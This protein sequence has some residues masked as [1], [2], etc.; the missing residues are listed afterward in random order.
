MKALGK[1]FIP[2]LVI[3]AVCAACLVQAE[4]EELNAFQLHEKKAHADKHQ[5]EEKYKFKGYSSYR[6]AFAQI[7]T[8]IEQDG[9]LNWMTSKAQQY[10]YLDSDCVPCRTLY[11]SLNSTCKPRKPSPVKLKK[12]DK[13][14][15][16]TKVADSKKEGAEGEE[17]KKPVEVEVKKVEKK[18]IKLDPSTE[19]LDLISN[20]FR[21]MA[22]KEPPEEAFGYF[23]GVENLVTE[24]RDKDGKTEAEKIYYDTLA[25]FIEAPFKNEGFLTK[26]KNSVK[27]GDKLPIVDPSASIDELF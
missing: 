20:V 27:T 3:I 13:V 21:S 26:S 25:E 17:E 10:A 22:L 8:L 16:E 4:D 1:T 11:L 23:T 7:C 19:L 5:K 2:V 9:Q 24:M 14:T 15:E 18:I 6:P 12:K